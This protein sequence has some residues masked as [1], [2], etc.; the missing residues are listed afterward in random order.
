MY[1]SSFAN[2]WADQIARRETRAVLERERVES[3][4][5]ESVKN[6]RSTPS[7]PTT[8]HPSAPARVLSSI[9]ANQF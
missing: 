8:P 6:P 1:A 4:F 3:I 7:P 5:T 9:S 2:A